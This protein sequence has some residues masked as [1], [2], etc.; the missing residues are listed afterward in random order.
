[1][2][3]ASNSEPSSARII[4]SASIPMLQSDSVRDRSISSTDRNALGP[5]TNSG[6]RSII[7]G[8]GNDRLAKCSSPGLRERTKR[9][10]LGT[11]L[12]SR[13]PIDHPFNVAQRM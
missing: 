13:C 4:R 10:K 8:L 1:M 11:G 7:L 9:I 5:S 12:L 3:G 2:F 6:A